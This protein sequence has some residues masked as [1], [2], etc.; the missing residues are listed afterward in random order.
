MIRCKTILA[1]PPYSYRNKKTGGSMK[2]GSADKY[3]V[4]TIEEISRIQVQQI[5]HKDCCLFQWVPVPLLPEGLWIMK[6]WGF[7]YKTAIFWRKTG[8]LGLGFWWRGCI[9]VCLFGVQGKVPAFRSSREN[10]IGSNPRQHSTKPDELYDLI[11]PHVP[12]PKMEL[13]ARRRRNGWH[14]MGNQI[15]T[16]VEMYQQGKLYFFR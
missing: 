16:D 6:R 7:S 4:M 5:A 14:A 9:E 13:F 12:D 10:M 11:E 8:R 3:P 2:S 15:D 1:D